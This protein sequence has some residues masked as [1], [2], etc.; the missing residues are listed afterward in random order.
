MKIPLP[1]ASERRFLL[2][3]YLHSH[4]LLLLRS[5]K[6]DRQSKLAQS[7]DRAF[8]TSLWDRALRPLREDTRRTARRALKPNPTL[9]G[10]RTPGNI[11]RATSMAC[12]PD[13]S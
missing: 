6:P 4:G 2:I 3:Q 9:P 12:W 5:N 13:R 8:P 7:T 10:Q 11:W 1:C